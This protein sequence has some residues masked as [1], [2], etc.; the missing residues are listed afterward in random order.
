MSRRAFLA[1]AVVLFL[2]FLSVSALAAS[3]VLP[4]QKSLTK[5]FKMAN[6][7]TCPLG[8]PSLDTV[9]IVLDCDHHSIVGPGSDVGVTVSADRAVVKNCE[10]SGFKAGVVMKGLSRATLQDSRVKDNEVGL[11]IER[12]RDARVS[13]VDFVQN[14]RAGIYSKG[15]YLTSLQNFFAGNGKDIQAV[16]PLKNPPSPEQPT[17][18]AVSFVEEALPSSIMSEA[19]SFPASPEVVVFDNR[20]TEGMMSYLNLDS[21]L[22]LQVIKSL[23]VRKAVRL[24][25]DGLVFS[26]VIS[27]K[28]PMDG[29]VVYEVLP[30][31][32]TDSPLDVSSFVTHEVVG[33]GPVVVKFFIGSLGRDEELQV[34][35]TVHSAGI[36]S[37]LA[38]PQS[39]YPSSVL[40]TEHPVGWQPSTWVEWLFALFVFLFALWIFEDVVNSSKRIMADLIFAAAVVL[41][42]LSYDLDL[43]VLIDR[44]VHQLVVFSVLFAACLFYGSRTWLLY[45]KS[46]FPQPPRSQPKVS[47]PSD[48]RG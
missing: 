16:D 46:K 6:D 35:Y 14:S 2:L 10:I 17:A 36:E 32:L 26:T 25:S 34:L 48:R 28:E 11:I 45:V 9:D 20:V 41:F 15:S 19:V 5:S 27:A 23:D 7:W 44:M 8:G 43:F 33:S 21:E 4:C 30:D 13:S 39:A 47:R 40:H 37:V 24:D 42:F 31:S 3:P 38:I 1:L 12:V 18:V 29:I 22:H